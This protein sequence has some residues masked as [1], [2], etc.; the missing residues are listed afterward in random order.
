MS[1][2]PITFAPA[3]VVTVALFG[4]FAAVMASMYPAW[5]ASGIEPA[6]AVRYE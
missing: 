2:L 4:L 6:Q 3:H 5:K 1:D